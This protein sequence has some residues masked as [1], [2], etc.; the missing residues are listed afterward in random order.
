MERIISYS[1]LFELYNPWFIPLE[2]CETGKIC[3][4]DKKSADTQKNLLNKDITNKSKMYK[5]LGGFIKKSY[6]CNM[7]GN[8]HLT[9]TDDEE[10]RQNRIAT[11]HHQPLKHVK[12]FQKYLKED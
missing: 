2:K 12:S 5:K 8:W 4:P 7:C 6:L 10:L 1:R 3:Y 11:F 9:T